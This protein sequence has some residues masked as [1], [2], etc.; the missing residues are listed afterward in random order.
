MSSNNPNTAPM[1]RCD[2][3]CSEVILPSVIRKTPTAIPTV[4][5]TIFSSD[6]A[7]GD[8]KEV[9]QTFD[10]KV[11]LRA[12]LPIRKPDAGDYVFNRRS[13]SS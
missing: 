4:H 6:P 2:H 12:W 5:Q 7:I 11:V 3:A 9:R 1:N 10:E 13:P 8:E